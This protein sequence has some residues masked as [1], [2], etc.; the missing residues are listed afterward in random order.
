[1]VSV[2]RKVC[3][4]IL[5]SVK[6]RKI[7]YLRSKKIISTKFCICRCLIYDDFEAPMFAYIGAFCNFMGFQLLKCL[8]LLHCQYNEFVKFPKIAIFE[9]LTLETAERFGK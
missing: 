5:F 1:M 3:R 8:I 7:I 9:K 2:S 4:I 6:N